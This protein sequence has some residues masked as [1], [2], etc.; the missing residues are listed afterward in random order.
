[1]VRIPAGHSL[2]IQP[3]T[4]MVCSSLKKRCVIN[5]NFIAEDMS[6]AVTKTPATTETSPPVNGMEPPSIAP[7]SAG[8][9]KNRSKKKRDAVSS[10][11]STL[12]PIPDVPSASST[13]TPEV[14]GIT[15]STAMSKK[16]KKKKREKKEKGKASSN[17]NDSA[18]PIVPS[19]QA[20]S[21]STK[22]SP[23]NS[24]DKTTQDAQPPPEETPAP[25]VSHRTVRLLG[26]VLIL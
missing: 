5:E 24:E 9:T 15:T 7:L 14:E 18:S 11:S 8:P 12:Q 3:Q 26:L 23:A 4:V 22:S 19:D 6:V 20:I 2:R 1:M 13:V 21:P 25:G 17:L 10:L 16:E